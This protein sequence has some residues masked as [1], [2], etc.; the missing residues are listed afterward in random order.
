[1]R[2]WVVII[3]QMSADRLQNYQLQR[4]AQELKRTLEVFGI[5]KQVPTSPVRQVD[6]PHYPTLEKPTGVATMSYF[7][8]MQ[9]GLRLEDVSRRSKEVAK[10]EGDPKI[11]ISIIHLS[12]AERRKAQLTAEK[13]YGLSR[14]YE[15]GLCTIFGADAEPGPGEF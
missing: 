11:S 1:M 12:R 15:V 10:E 4:L 2:L 3:L 6:T 13:I 7:L 9:L 5:D 14:V 8:R